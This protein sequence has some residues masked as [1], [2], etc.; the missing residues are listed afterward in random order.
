MSI[1][2]L[3]KSQHVEFTT[4]LDIPG[5]GTLVFMPDTPGR[6]ILVSPKS[7]YL[8]AEKVDNIAAVLQ[9]V[10]SILPQAVGQQ[11]KRDHPRSVTSV[12][13]VRSRVQKPESRKKT[14]RSVPDEV[15]N[16]NKVSTSR[17]SS[18]LLTS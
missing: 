18:L 3:T 2:S 14:P 10:S 9:A 17:I 1:Y 12:K 13:C 4:L 7:N 5:T 8:L 6:L 15:L 16:T 11:S